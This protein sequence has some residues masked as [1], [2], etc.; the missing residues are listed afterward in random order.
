MDE[1]QGIKSLLRFKEPSPIWLPNVISFLYSEGFTHKM[2]RYEKTIEFLIGVFKC[3]VI[4]VIKENIINLAATFYGKRENRH[5][6]YESPFRDT[7]SFIKSYNQTVDKLNE[8]RS[9]NY[10][11]IDF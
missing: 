6:V 10:K 8:L 3:R 9:T 11:S 4:I 2:Y 1:L 5:N 7:G